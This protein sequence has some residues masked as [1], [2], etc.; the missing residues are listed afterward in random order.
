MLR[1]IAWPWILTFLNASIMWSTIFH[2]KRISFG[3][4][5]YGLCFD[6]ALSHW[7]EN[8]DRPYT[9]VWFPK[10][11]TR[12]QRGKRN[13]VPCT[14]NYVVDKW[15]SLI[16]NAM[17][18]IHS[19]Q[20]VSISQP[21]IHSIVQC[22]IVKIW[23]FQCSD[24]KP[25]SILCYVIFRIFSSTFPVAYYLFFLCLNLLLCVMDHETDRY[26]V[27]YLFFQS[28]SFRGW[29]GFIAVK[30]TFQQHRAPINNI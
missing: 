28:R 11:K 30:S 1:I 22:C 9:S 17:N 3:T 20:I 2:N 13:L 23:C 25:T 19:L 21:N 6:L 5:Q 15:S 14:I 27:N 16:S 24:F 26:S 29:C 8:V 18:W 4:K 12:I 7:N 10:H